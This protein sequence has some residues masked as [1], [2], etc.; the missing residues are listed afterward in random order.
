MKKYSKRIIWDYINGEDMDGYDIV[1][2]EDDIN[3]M[4]MVICECNDKNMY[5]MCG[6]NL[7]KNFE[8]IKFLINKFHDDKDFII[9]IGQEYMNQCDEFETIELKIILCDYLKDNASDEFM[10]YRLSL[11]MFYI[12][13]RLL[14]ESY[15]EQ[16]NNM[17][18]KNVNS[19]GFDII[20][21]EYNHSDIIKNFFAKN[22]LNEIFNLGDL[23]FEKMLHLRFKNKKELCAMGINNFLIQYVYKHD[24]FLSGYVS[25]HIDLLLDLHK[26][27]INFLERWDKYEMIKNREKMEIL[28]EEVDKFINE[29]L[30]L[31]GMEMELFKYI[32]VKFDLEEIFLNSGISLN[33]FDENFQGTYDEIK[34]LKINELR[35]DVLSCVKKFISRIEGVCYFGTVPDDYLEEVVNQRKKKGKLLKLENENSK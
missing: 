12:Q 14:C 22:M 5:N 16:L 4:M 8:F 32:L 17:F 2:L 19:L 3:F 31:V 26:R 21:D 15:M 29:N 11:D 28:L 27:I 1:K 23:N 7:K 10:K 34:D 18:Y 20:L 9:M 13:Q 6:D 33:Y 24:E 35:L 25:V 30:S